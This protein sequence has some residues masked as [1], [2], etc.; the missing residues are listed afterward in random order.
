MWFCNCDF[1]IVILHNMQY[2]MCFCTMCKRQP[3]S[4][5]THPVCVSQLPGITIR[6]R[7]SWTSWVVLEVQTAPAPYFGPKIGSKV[8]KLDCSGWLGAPI[9]Q[10]FGQFLRSKIWESRQK[11]H[12]K[13][14][15]N[16][17]TSEKRGFKYFVKGQEKN[18]W[19]CNLF[20]PNA[21][22]KLEDG[23]RQ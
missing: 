3:P 22:N 14:K 23:H 7:P 2:E 5:P 10:K 19:L 17:V 12:T 18:V 20:R 4:I 15:H 16:I 11:L 13:G 6:V 8:A 1:A 21:L 9:W